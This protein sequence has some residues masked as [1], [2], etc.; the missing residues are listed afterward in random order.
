M[1]ETPLYGRFVGENKRLVFAPT[2]PYVGLV[3]TCVIGGFAAALAGVLFPNHLP[4]YAAW[5]VFT[6]T[7]VGLAG[8]AAA[9][10]IEL[11]VFDLKERTYRRRQGPGLFPRTSRGRLQDLDAVVL[12]SE[13]N[14]LIG[15]VTYH[16]ILH[17]KQMRE[18]P[19]VLQQD[20]RSIHPGSPLNAAAGP[21]YQR[22]AEYARALG[23]PFYD[24]SH[25]PS[26]NP[27]PML[28]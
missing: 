22:G 3:R 1:L 14:P 20:S 15:G 19:L 5:W 7:M 21:I 12:I 17:W 2:G 6:G 27:V 26:A 18:P 13:P 4:V 28:R 25:F 9:F 16:L 8:V 11:V 23:L 10:A 24:N